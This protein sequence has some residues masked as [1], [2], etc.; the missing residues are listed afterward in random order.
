MN[1]E[2]TTNTGAVTLKLIGLEAAVFSLSRRART[3]AEQRIAVLQDDENPTIFDS[4]GNTGKIGELE[5]LCRTTG[6]R[7]W[8]WNPNYLDHVAGLIERLQLAEKSWIA[9]L[10]ILGGE[11]EPDWLEL[12]ACAKENLKGRAQELGKLLDRW[13]AWR[14]DN[15]P[16]CDC[17]MNYLLSHRTAHT[18]LDHAQKTAG[19]TGGEAPV[20]N[21]GKPQW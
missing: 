16:V 6:H 12:H 11:T 14:S 20:W 21:E 17:V 9:E 8:E 5:R 10:P 15:L 13:T 2:N 3:C 4:F 1:T 19:M 7:G 18:T